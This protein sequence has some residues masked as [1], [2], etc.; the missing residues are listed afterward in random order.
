MKNITVSIDDELYRVARIA[1]AQRGTSVSALVRDYLRSLAPS[2][3]G[4]QEANR[5]LFAAMD[6]AK[7]LRAADRL[8]RDASH[9]R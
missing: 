6:K 5:A 2:V 4:Q 9:A 7:H 8:S 3:A 1:A